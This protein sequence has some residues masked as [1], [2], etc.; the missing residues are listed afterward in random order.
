RPAIVELRN[1]G[2]HITKIQ[3]GAIRSLIGVLKA[4]GQR[5][6]ARIERPR[7]QGVVGMNQCNVEGTV[8]NYDGEILY[9]LT[10]G[11]GTYWP[12]TRIRPKNG[13]WG[14][15]VNVGTR[16]PTA[17]IRLVKVDERLAEYIDFYRAKAG[18]LGHSGMTISNLP[19]P[20]DEVRVTV[21]R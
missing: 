17:T 14:E 8:E 1:L 13:R 16:L 9:L 18:A 5:F 15:V 10:G 12:S 2:Q 7:P 6:S 20:I 11:D 3:E 19:R 21:D 4:A